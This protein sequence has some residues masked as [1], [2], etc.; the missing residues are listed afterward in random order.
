MSLLRKMDRA[1]GDADLFRAQRT[2][3]GE[4]DETFVEIA[5]MKRLNHPNI[6]RLH[7]VIDDPVRQKVRPPRR[8]GALGAAVARL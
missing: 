4:M 2:S 6:V 3:D 1:V 7:E 5:I 8:R